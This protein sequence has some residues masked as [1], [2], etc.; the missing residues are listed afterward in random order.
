MTNLYNKR[1]RPRT[2][3]VGD[4]V[5]RRV[6]ENTANPAACKLQP[7]L[8]GSYMIVKVEATDSY[9]LNKLNGTL[10][11]RMWN[12]THLKRYYQ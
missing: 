2:F 1:V 5:L 9:A 7:N 12:A 10:V 6:F 3:K 4:L 11:R 8:E